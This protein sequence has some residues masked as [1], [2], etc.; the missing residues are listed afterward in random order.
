MKKISSLF[1][2]LAFGVTSYAQA[3]QQFN[4]QGVARDNMGDILANQNI[5]LQL[6][7]LSGSIS[8]TIEYVETQT[9][10]TNDFGLFTVQIGDGTVVSGSFGAIGWGGNSHFI[11]VE[12]DAAG[13]TSYT[14]TGT[15]QLLSVPYALYAETA[16]TSGTTGPTGPAG[17]T[18]PTGSNGSNGAAGPTGPTGPTG[19][20]ASGST[21]QTLYHNGS[22]WTASSNLYHNGTNVGIGTTSPSAKLG[23]SSGS[24]L[25]L[26]VQGSGTTGVF[27]A[28]IENT[29]NGTA[30]GV[31]SNG[32]L[33]GFPSTPSAI[34]SRGQA[35]SHGIFTVA[36]SSGTR[37]LMAQGQNGAGAVYGWVFSGAGYSGEF[38][39]GS[40]VLING[41]LQSDQ[42]GIGTPSS[43]YQ[44]EVAG[45]AGST[46]NVVF[47]ESNYSGSSD[48][49]AI[50][51]VSTP[52]NGY[53]HGLHATG[54]YRGAEAHGLGG[55]F[56]GGQLIDTASVTTLG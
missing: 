5:G 29:G 28:K 30:L 43:L 38:I 17:A 46:E 6:S 16:G 37:A 4:Y 41:G 18:G 55:S 1:M 31:S 12:M 49:Y 20:I 11:K 54:A 25:G 9:A 7:V 48:V 50:E 22:S 51:A 27:A 26:S 21:G 32:I 40:G 19:T 14:L 15:S 39:G 2:A 47:V 44:L 3:P 10:T 42:V 35:G 34:Y 56:S 33:S 45:D 13:G 36:N 52:A 8:G 53:G 23:V 24:S